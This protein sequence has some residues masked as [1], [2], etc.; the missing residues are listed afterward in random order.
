MSATTRARPSGSIPR[1][2]CFIADAMEGRSPRD[3]GLRDLHQDCSDRTPSP[4][5]G[6]ACSRFPAAS[7]PPVR[8]IVPHNLRAGREHGLSRKGALDCP[9]TD[10]AVRCC[11]WRSRAALIE[12]KSRGGYRRVTLFAHRH[13]ALQLVGEVFEEDHVILRLP[14]SLPASAPRCVCHGC[15]RATF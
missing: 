13:F 14:A 2:K 4:G 8:P 15:R 10:F 6:T 9:N 3:T 11:A 12:L 1:G 5:G 7:H